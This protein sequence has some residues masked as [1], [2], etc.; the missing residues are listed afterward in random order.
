MKQKK[1]FTLVE[2]LAVITILAII[3]LIATPMV[4]NIVK[5]AQQGAF[6][7]SVDNV[8][9]AGE[10]FYLDAEIQGIKGDTRFECVDNKCSSDKTNRFG[11]IL[12]LEVKGDMG[13]GYVIVTSDGDIELALERSKYCATKYRFGEEVNIIQGTCDGIDLVNDSTNPIINKITTQKGPEAIKVV[14]SAYDPESGISFYEYS[15]DGG[16]SWTEKVRNNVYTFTG[17]SLGTYQ[18]R[19]RVYNGTAESTNYDPAT[20]MTM[21]NIVTV[22]VDGTGTVTGGSGSTGGN[23]G[24]NPGGNNPGGPT[25]GGTCI[26]P[27]VTSVLPEGWATAKTVRVNYGDGCTSGEYSLDGGLTWNTGSSISVTSETSKIIFA[28]N[29][30]TSSYSVAGLKPI[31]QI[32][33]TKASGSSITI[34]YK[35]NADDVSSISCEFGKTD[36]YGK[37][38]TLSA[39]TKKCIL[40]GLEENETYFYKISVTGSGDNKDATEAS[41]RTLSPSYDTVTEGSAVY[42]NPNVGK[43]CNNYSEESQSKTGVYDGCLKW[44]V[45]RDNG[46][47]TMDMILDH[48]AIGV[49]AYNSDGDN[50]TQKEILESLNTI[51]SK[52]DSSV[53]HT[54]RLISADEIAKTTKIDFN[55]AEAK[56][57]QDDYYY[58]NNSSNAWLFN[59][60]KGCITN[61]C[62]IEPLTNEVGYWTSTRVT[63][64]TGKVWA[65]DNKG[66]LTNGLVR[67]ETNNWGVRPVITVNAE[68]LR[69][70]PITITYYPN[71]TI[72]DN[73][74]YYNPVTG[75][76]CNDYIVGN[77]YQNVKTGCLKWYRFKNN[78]DGTVDMILDHNIVASV[79]WGT[80]MATI[81]T[82]LDENTS[83]WKNRARLITADEIAGLTGMTDSFHA[84]SSSSTNWF[85]FYDG[86]QTLKTTTTG[87]NQYAWLYDYT[88]DCTSYG[89]SLVPGTSSHGYWTSTKVAGEDYVW[90]VKKDGSLYYLAPT[91]TNIGLRPVITIDEEIVNNPLPQPTYI[92]TA[93][94]KANPIYLD[95]TNLTK[96]CTASGSTSTTG[97]KT[98]CMKWYMFKDNND[99][100]VDLLLDHNTSS[101][102]AWNSDNT[103]TEMK[104]IATQFATDTT[105]W[106]VDAR[107]ITANEIA[108]ITGNTTWTSL[109][110]TGNFYFETNTSSAPSKYTKAY[111]W[112]FDYTKGCTNYGCEIDDADGGL[113]YWT[114]TPMAGNT[115]SLWGVGSVKNTSGTGL[116]VYFGGSYLGD[117]VAAY[118]N[119]GLRP[120]ITVSKTTLGL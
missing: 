78:N 30:G 15:I 7:R 23:T 83:N 27:V 54:I 41:A 79:Q 18:V 101:N 110:S 105:G 32:T 60:T 103:N 42:F 92:D 47:G 87:S 88:T 70:T 72:K 46:D 56:Q 90:Y 95:P 52:W 49:V 91:T 119:Y 59:Y 111:S 51:S 33:D 68:T 19:V 57:E 64:T 44:Y 85:Y 108:N 71:S 48:N 17:L 5:R 98:G 40:D 120:V 25:G 114:N 67:N 116:V 61:N 102:I 117:Q 1:G 66:R 31:V 106:K 43:V 12:A 69:E 37:K 4:L 24:N 76:M 84:D 26:E 63:G 65:V 8:I 62:S 20:G 38:G 89:C 3:A 9:K 80:D 115:R 2:V 39:E 10:L 104:E 93:T 94:V 29:A 58:F 28:T 21:S 77:S 109:K 112:L 53:K 97:T 81:K 107:L 6:L 55:S 82:S 100:T 22:D 74:V 13:E 14:V 11:E 86:S 34:S 118:K 36:S 96:T 35:L 45:Y 16:Q 113:G 50:T 99:G 75:L 73:P